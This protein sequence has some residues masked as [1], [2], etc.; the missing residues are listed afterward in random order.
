[1]AITNGSF[2]SL[3]CSN[4]LLPLGVR[5]L[6]IFCSSIGN[7]AFLSFY[8]IKKVPFLQDVFIKSQ[9]RDHKVGKKQLLWNL[10]QTPR[11]QARS[12]LAMQ[13]APIP[14]FA[15]RGGVGRKSDEGERATKK[16]T[17]WWSF[18][19]APL[20]GLEPNDPLTA[21]A[22]NFAHAKL[23]QPR[24]ARGDRWRKVQQ[25]GKRQKE[26]RGDCLGFFLAPL[27]GLEPTTP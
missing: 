11:S 15:R 26:N 24:G 4:L 17:D 9:V 14:R 6:G 22:H 5:F 10:N 2:S 16:T 27:V 3:N 1:M 25:G 7:T 20:V 21:F 18:S 12:Q 8:Y 23:P 19:L 13:V